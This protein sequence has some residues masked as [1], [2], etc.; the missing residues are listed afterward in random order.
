LELR[1]ENTPRE[2]YLIE[3]SKLQNYAVER[4]YSNG[5]HQKANQISILQLKS[6]DSQK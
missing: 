3:G 5:L 6:M 4:N 2:Q 1:L